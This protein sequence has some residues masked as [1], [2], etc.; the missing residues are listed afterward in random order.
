[1]PPRQGA[2]WQ[3]EILWCQ[4][5]RAKRFACPILVSVAIQFLKLGLGAGMGSQYPFQ[6][7]LV[8][9]DLWI[10]HAGFEPL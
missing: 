1:M 4:A 2:H 6:R 3:G 10:C 8:A 5:Q 7:C 9:K